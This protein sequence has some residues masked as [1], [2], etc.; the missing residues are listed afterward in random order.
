MKRR[1]FIPLL[2]S[3]V[4]SWPLAA[5]AQQNVM[6]V[7]G[8][9]SLGLPSPNSVAAFRQGLADA[10]Y[11]RGQNV[12]IEFRS[13]DLQNLLL[14]QLAADLVARKVNVIV[15]TVSPSVAVAAKAATSKIP[16]VFNVLDDPRK[17]GLVAGLNRP[18]G[19]L[20]GM[21]FLATEL[22]GKRLNLLIEAVSRTATIAYLSRSRNP[23]FEAQRSDILA[24]AHALGR[25]I[26]IAPVEERNFEAAFATIVQRRAG[27]LIV[28]N[29]AFSWCQAI[30]NKF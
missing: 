17:Y 20:T 1:E 23:S 2:G 16:I 18:E 30:E 27:A 9:L 22:A 13:A 15:T 26:F 25:D 7:I 10:G 4:A 24:A 8:F 11:I 6:P 19:N 21:N 12:V 3:A 29:Y 28:G 5:R 14:P